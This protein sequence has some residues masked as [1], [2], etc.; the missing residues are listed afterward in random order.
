MVMP[1]PAVQME[2]G[3]LIVPNEVVERRI[4]LIRGEKVMIDSDLAELYQVTTGNLNLAVRRNA[5]RFPPDFMF[6]LSEE[7]FENLILQSARS[8]WGGRRK[9]PYVFTEHGVAMLSAVLRSR[10]AIEMSI[11]IVRAFVKL[12]EMVASNRELA[13]RMQNLEAA[14]R[15][16]ASVINILVGE[17]EDLKM[18]PS[19]PARRI[20]FPA[21]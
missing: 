1:K 11:L 21:D 13:L 16:H 7:E 3:V 12:R 14:Q 8:R 5:E 6:Q 18:L 10:R 9:R 2:R 15:D 17:I 4:Y 20:G 19:A